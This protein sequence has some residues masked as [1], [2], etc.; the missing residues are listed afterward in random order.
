VL[1]TGKVDIYPGAIQALVEEV[2]PVEAEY[3]PPTVAVDVLGGI[4]GLL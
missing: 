3:S 4:A 1:S 2:R